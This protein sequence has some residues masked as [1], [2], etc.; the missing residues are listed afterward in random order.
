M[1]HERGNDKSIRKSYLEF[2]KYSQ[3]ESTGQRGGKNTNYI[4]QILCGDMSW[5][6]PKTCNTAVCPKR[7]TENLGLITV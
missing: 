1:I 7:N 6:W 2:E 3:W 4:I 5:I